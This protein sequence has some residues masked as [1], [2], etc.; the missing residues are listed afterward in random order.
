MRIYHLFFVYKRPFSAF[1]KH[2]FSSEMYLLPPCSLQWLLPPVVLQVLLIG[3]NGRKHYHFTEL[4]LEFQ[5]HTIYCFA[6]SLPS[7]HTAHKISCTQISFTESFS[8]QLTVRISLLLAV[9]SSNQKGQKSSMYQKKACKY[10]FCCVK[11]NRETVQLKK[12][13]LEQ[14]EM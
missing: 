12:K 9:G 3:F 14:T 1:R 7:N 13:L 5:S 6:G 4:C 10:I 11:E 2:S 8:I